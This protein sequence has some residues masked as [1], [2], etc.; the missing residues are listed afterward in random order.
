MQLT[1]ER[2]RWMLDQ[3]SDGFAKDAITGARARAARGNDFQIELG[4]SVTI[5]D[6]NTLLDISAW[7]TVTFTLK[8]ESN[9]GGA[10]L[11][12]KSI[13][14]GALNLLLSQAG[15]DAG[16]DQ[17]AIIQFSAAETNLDL[18]NQTEKIF[19]WSVR[20]GTNVGTTVTVGEGELV[21]YDDGVAGNPTPTPPLGSS[22]IPAGTI[23]SGAGAYVLNGLTAGQYYSWEKG[24]NDTDLVNGGETLTSTR[25]F[26]AQGTSVTLHGTASALITALVRWPRVY[27]APEVD[28]KFAGVPKIINDAGVLTGWTSPNGKI[29]R[30]SGV[31]DDLLPIDQIIDL[32]A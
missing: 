14:A 10:T 12:Q 3:Q 31:G 22:L 29:L 21:L 24:A 1:R 7:Q 13:S 23:Y 27:T 4:F 6:V 30:L 20:V 28:A 19:Y 8:D 15:W 9:R 32:T 17:H 18:G 5:G 16:T 26:L 11:M 25:W 2:I